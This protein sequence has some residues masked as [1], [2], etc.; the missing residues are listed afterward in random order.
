MERVIDTII[1]IERQA[2][3]LVRD[4][5][6]QQKSLEQSI[7]AETEDIRRRYR[8]RADARLKKVEDAERGFYEESLSAQ[9]K[10]RDEQM[11]A[12][13]SLIREKMNEWSEE[14]FERII[15]DSVL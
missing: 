5:R 7:V 13:D 15:G 11:S 2:Q 12:M 14:I 1:E 10:K 4:C 9:R 8:E 6:E 3:E